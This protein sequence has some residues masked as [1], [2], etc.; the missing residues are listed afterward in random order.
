MI[1][2]HYNFQM[3]DSGHCQLSVKWIHPGYPGID[4]N[5]R[6]R[7]NNI[8]RTEWQTPGMCELNNVLIKS[9]TRVDNRHIEIYSGGAMNFRVRYRGRKSSIRGGVNK[10][11]KKPF[12]HGGW[13]VYL[14][15]YRDIDIEYR[16]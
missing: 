6:C 5:V 2:N 9:V 1:R 7:C 4:E 13:G 8:N 12:F 16:F 14:Y 11:G 15:G 3:W 10:K